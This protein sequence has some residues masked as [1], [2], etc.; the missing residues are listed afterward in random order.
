MDS[1]DRVVLSHLG[2]AVDLAEALPHEQAGVVVGTS[3]LRGEPDVR[4][5]IGQAGSRLPS[6]H[7]RDRTQPLR[8]DV[9]VSGADVPVPPVAPRRSALHPGHQGCTS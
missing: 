7:V 9:E 2:Q 4:H 6:P 5:S 3:R 1:A 8:V